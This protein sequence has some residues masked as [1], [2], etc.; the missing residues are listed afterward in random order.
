MNDAEESADVSLDTDRLEQLLEVPAPTQPVVMIEYRNRGVP[1]WL[2][3]TLVVLVPLVAVVAYQQ[4]VVQTYQAQ[5]AK[6]RYAA[7]LLETQRA[8]EAETRADRPAVEAI[9]ANA[10]SS[11][12]PIVISAQVAPAPAPAS[13]QPPVSPAGSDESKPNPAPSEVTG[14]PA[15]AGAGQPQEARVRSIFPISLEPAAAGA[16]PKGAAAGSIG[17]ATGSPGRTAPHGAAN[18]QIAGVQQPRT[19]AATAPAAGRPAGDGAPAPL[20]AGVGVGSVDAAPQPQL[21]PRIE[22]LPTPEEMRSQIVEEAAKMEAEKAEER[23][24]LNDR[25]RVRR[26]EDRIK[27][28]DE[29]R[30]ILAGDVKIAG[31]EIDA[32]V[33]RQSGDSDLRTRAKARRIWRNGRLPLAARVSQIRSLDVPESDILNLMSDNLHARMHAPGGPRDANEVRV[34]AARLLL[35]CELTAAAGVPAAASEPARPI[36]RGRTVT[37]NPPR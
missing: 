28:H 35:S 29:L 25:L 23:L 2:L 37:D 1:W 15:V 8:V 9:P 24:E 14:G 5:A 4:L 21:V 13:T 34:R 19:D 10:A 12:A 32:L 18:T 22:P 26:Y 17:T 33:K 11:A 3:V 20:A 27:F 36:G 16:G 30:Q 7:Q 6:A 31:A